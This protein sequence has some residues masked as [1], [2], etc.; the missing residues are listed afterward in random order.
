MLLMSAAGAVM[1]MFVSTPVPS[2]VTVSASKRLPGEGEAS[3]T[4]GAAAE[5]VEEVITTLTDMP[6]GKPSAGADA[7]A[8]NEACTT[9]TSFCTAKICHAYKL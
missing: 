7:A 8:P 4:K 3:T 1:V 2:P 6:G 5:L 9:A